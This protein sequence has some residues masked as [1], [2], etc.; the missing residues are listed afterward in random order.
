MA[1]YHLGETKKKQQKGSPLRAVPF[2]WY[3]CKLGNGLWE[4]DDV[5]SQN[6]HQGLWRHRKESRMKMRIKLK[7]DQREV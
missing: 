7:T 1:V 3:D 5:L 6:M 4:L 2:P